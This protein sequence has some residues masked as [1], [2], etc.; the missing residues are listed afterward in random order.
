VLPSQATLTDTVAGLHDGGAEIA[1]EDG[2]AL[3]A[4][5]LGTASGW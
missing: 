1:P 4:D 2:D 5:P 3:L